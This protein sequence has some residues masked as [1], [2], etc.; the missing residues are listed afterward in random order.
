LEKLDLTVNFIADLT[1]VE[2]L[3]VNREL[4]DLY[5]TGNPCCTYDGYRPYV[6]ATLTQVGWREGPRRCVEVASCLTRVPIS[7]AQLTSL[8]GKAVSRS[9][10][11]LGKV[12]V[13][14]AKTE[15]FGLIPCGHQLIFRCSAASPPRSDPRARGAAAKGVGTDARGGWRTMETSWFLLTPSISP[16]P[17]LTIAL[18]CGSRGYCV[19]RQRARGLVQDETNDVRDDGAPGNNVSSSQKQKKN[20][21]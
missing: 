18:E 17:L 19:S 20:A 13:H 21:R 9:E 12:H 16:R 5:L 15:K 11:I 8:D 7:L 6:I 2:S 4:R 10:R 3:C 1:S 14:R